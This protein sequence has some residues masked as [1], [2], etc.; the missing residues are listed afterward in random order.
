MLFNDYFLKR[1]NKNAIQ[2]GGGKASER[3]EHDLYETPE[4]FTRQFLDKVKFNNPV[5]EPCCGNGRISNVLK[6]Y[7]YDVSSSDIV[8]RDFDC[9]VKNFIYDDFEIGKFD[10]CTNPPFKLLSEFVA[11][12]SC[13]A[14]DKFCFVARIQFLESIGRYESF[15][16][17]GINGFYLSKVLCATKRVDFVSVRQTAINSSAMMCAWFVFERGERQAVIDWIID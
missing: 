17:D 3:V 5:L 6:E 10:I 12:S 9:E 14:K 4:Y 2:I 13:V 8:K 1:K 16:K 15:F 11:K 7:G